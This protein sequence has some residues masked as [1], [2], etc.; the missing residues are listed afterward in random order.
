VLTRCVDTSEIYEAMEWRILLL[1]IGTVGIGAGM[2]KCGLAGQLARSI[3]GV[4]SQ[5][6]DL[7]VLSAVYLIAVILTEFL[8]NAAV[9]AIITPIAMQT[10]LSLQV[11]PKPFVIAAMFGSTLAFSTPIGYQTNLLVYNAGGYKFTD[12]CRIGIPL[13]LLLWLLCTFLIPVFW[14]LTRLP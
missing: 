2:E 5:F 6:G 7:A 8:S 9:A 3:V 11:D 1:I 4:F 10:A 14:P 12:F 13:T